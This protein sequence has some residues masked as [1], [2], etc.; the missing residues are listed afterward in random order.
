MATEETEAY[1]ISLGGEIRAVDLAPWLGAAEIAKI[2]A[3]LKRVT[4][5]LAREGGA[6]W[7]RARR[8][9]VHHTSSTLR[10]RAIGSKTSPEYLGRALITGLEDSE[11]G[12]ERRRGARFARSCASPPCCAKLAEQEAERLFEQIEMPW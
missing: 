2:G 6:T 12:V 1:V 10:G 7:S 8:R 5:L 3:D 11:H 9:R 4:V